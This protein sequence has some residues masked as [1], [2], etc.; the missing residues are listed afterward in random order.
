MSERRRTTSAASRPR[1]NFSWRAR[2]S[3]TPSRTRVS[4]SATSTASRRTW[5]RATTR[6]GCPRALG[7][8]NVAFTAQT[9]GGGGNG[10]AAAVA[11]ADAAVS[12]GYAKCVVVFRA[13]AQGQFGRYGQARPGNRV[14]RPPWRT[15]RLYGMLTPAHICAMQTTRFMH[16]HGITQDAL[17]EIALAATRTP[18]ATR[19][20]SATASRS[21]ARTYHASRWI[22]EPF[23]LYDCCPEND[24]AAAVVITTR[25]RA[26]DLQHKPVPIVAAAQGLGQRDGAALSTKRASPR[27]TT[28]K[29]AS[30]S[31]GGR[32]RGRRTSRS[33]S[34]TRTSPARC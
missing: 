23:H 7:I 10:V 14:G 12:A 5:T 21:L 30:R 20:R 24:G 32:A 27:P 18:S 13:L 8:E 11:L 29:S 19:G 4:R 34:S 28:A 6:C 25:E 15:A 17:A 3:A 16:E 22:V 1:A 33:R 9:W 2:R 31:G 26:R